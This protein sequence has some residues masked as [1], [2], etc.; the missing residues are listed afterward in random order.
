MANAPPRLV[1]LAGPNGA[2]KSTAAPVLLAETLG[3]HEFVNADDIA[4]GLSAFQPERVAVQA[5]RIMLQRLKELA[6]RR[7]TFALETTLAGRNYASWIAELR[8]GGY[9]CKLV[10]FWLPSPELA[11]Q[12]VQERVQRGGHSIPEETIRRRYDSGLRNFFDLYRTLVDEWSFVD[13]TNPSNPR[14]IADGTST[15][16][17]ILDPVTWERIRK[18]LSHEPSGTE[19]RE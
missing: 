5:G 7:A 2:G 10:Y 4:R 18:E 8:R 19:R 1:M 6:A 15:G 16:E 3:V 12:R 17:T 13:N 11:I 14:L 9:T